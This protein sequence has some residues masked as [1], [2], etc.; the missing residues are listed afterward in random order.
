MPVHDSLDME[1]VTRLASSVVG[2]V[3]RRADNAHESA[4]DSADDTYEEGEARA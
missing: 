1:E 4:V 3:C 2:R